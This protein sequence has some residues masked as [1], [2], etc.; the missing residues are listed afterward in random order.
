MSNRREVVDGS[1][2]SGRAG[3]NQASDLTGNAPGRD[4]CAR[5]QRMPFDH[6]RLDVYRRALDFMQIADA[7]IEALPRGRRH[8]ADQLSR[9]WTSIVLNIAA[10]AG[11]SSKPDKCRDYGSARGSATG[12][13]AVFDL[14][15][16]LKLVDEPSH[17]DGKALLETNRVDAREARQ[18]PREAG[19]GH[20]HGTG[21]SG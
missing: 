10:G 2:A 12:S 18:E 16:R 15:V 5:V 6:E 4:H 19:H 14:C 20:G 13:A 9:A 17:R 7:L 8:L 11:K 1:S 3:V 21:C